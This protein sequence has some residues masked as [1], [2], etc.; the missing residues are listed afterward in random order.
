V[1]KIFPDANLS[2]LE[3]HD[4]NGSGRVNYQDLGRIREDTGYE[5]EYGIERGIP[6]YVEWLRAG[7]PE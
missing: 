6:D 5:P 2:L 7:N 4:P 1:K 3:G